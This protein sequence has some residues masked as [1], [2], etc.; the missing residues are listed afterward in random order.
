MLSTCVQPMD[1]LRTNHGETCVRSSTIDEH[2][3]QL[4]RELCEQPTD[5]P[6]V[7]HSYTRHSSTPIITNLPLAEQKFYPVSTGPIIRTTK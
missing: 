6:Q 4:L 1:N 2:V 7:T 3:D 5:T